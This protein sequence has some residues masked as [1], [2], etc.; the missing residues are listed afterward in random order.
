MSS[1]LLAVPFAFTLAFCRPSTIDAR[2]SPDIESTMLSKSPKKFISLS[3]L[4]MSI[5]LSFLFDKEKVIQSCN[6]SNNCHYPVPFHS[7]HLLYFLLSF[8]T[9]L[10]TFLWSLLPISFNLF[11]ALIPS[12][13]PLRRSLI[14]RSVLTDSF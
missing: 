10:S 9:F 14:V 6:C 8:I 3:H 12:V 7:T 13:P 5:L 1:I 11:I 4:S 2:S